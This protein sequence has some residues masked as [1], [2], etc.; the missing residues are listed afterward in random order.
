MLVFGDASATF[1]RAEAAAELSRLA[2]E[3]RT[4]ASAFDRHAARVALLLTVGQL[5]QGVIDA[6][7]EALGFDEVSDTT[8]DAEAL[9]MTI[10]ARVVRSWDALVDG[11]G[12][13][14][15][16]APASEAPFARLLTHLPP[17]LTTRVPEGYEHYGVYVETYISSARRLRARSARAVSSRRPLVVGLRS[18]GAS[19]GAV[20]ACVLDA[21]LV[22]VRPRG[23]VFSRVVRIGPHLATKLAPLE[24]RSVTVVDEGP[25]ISGSSLGGAADWLEEHGARAISFLPSH[26]GELGDAASSR[27]RARW[28]CASRVVTSF[29]E[30]FLTGG[31]RTHL[32]EWFATTTGSG[33]RLERLHGDGWR[34]RLL[35]DPS[36]WPAAH[37]QQERAKYRL[38]VGGKSWLLKSAG[39]GRSGERKLGRAQLLADAGFCPRVH[40][41][42]H[43]FL[44]ADWHADAR[45]LARGE[46]WSLAWQQQAAAYLS[47]RR[48]LPP[49]RAGA[50]VGDL[51]VM[52]TTNTSEA[53]GPARAAVLQRF[54]DD[55]R[56]LAASARPVATDNK[57]QP[58]EW[59]ALP[60]G[61]LLKC[62]AVDHGDA[63]DLVGPQDIAWD[64][65]AAGVELDLE[66][67]W[68]EEQL[69]GPLLARRRRLSFYR[70]AYLAFSLGRASFA[71][72][73]CRED[74]ERDRWQG[75]Y[76]AYRTRLAS[77]LDRL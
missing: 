8:C 30:I 65:A 62:D 66:P 3:G 29:D 60:D 58:W 28:S 5:A 37:P 74:A 50:D 4:A 39:L 9:L 15:L 19:L 48:G 63:H 11:A 41:F 23:P 61:R 32:A 57:M 49:S 56:E 77:E 25:G 52:C 36:R 34:Q 47:F 10:A 76:D 67:A 26:T 6:S 40:A 73:S 69:E 72:A 54:A 24:E 35:G 70:A 59:I 51:F 20:V 38:T 44:L 71:R 14:E 27:H 43:G 16:V 55:L 2:H 33:G 53:L 31:G 18:I 13:D 21:D 68:E 42:R 45:P 1:T 75:E 22:T 17:T 46:R 64:I 12:D 7:A